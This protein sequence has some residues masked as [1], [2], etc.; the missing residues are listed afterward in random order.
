MAEISGT[1]VHRFSA[2]LRGVDVACTV[3]YRSEEPVVRVETA[4]SHLDSGLRAVSKFAGYC[5]RTLVLADAPSEDI[6]WACVLASYFGFGL[7]VW[8]DGVREEV[9]PP[10]PLD[11]SSPGSAT[12][13]FL[14]QVLAARP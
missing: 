3:T 14:R 1:Q 13:R 11:A 2:R 5:E 8:R 4:P 10:P 9:M 7:A 6:E 12:E